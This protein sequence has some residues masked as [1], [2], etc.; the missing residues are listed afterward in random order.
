MAIHYDTEEERRLHGNV[1][2]S[3]AD[4]YHLD[5]TVIREIYESRLESLMGAARVKIYLSVL[6]ARYVKSY[7][8]RAR[9]QGDARAT[10]THQVH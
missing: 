3:L 2:H 9:L 5:E 4:R 6:T 7:L 10:S 8:Y 1:I